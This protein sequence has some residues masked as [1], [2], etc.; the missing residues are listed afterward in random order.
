M[1]L[2]GMSGMSGMNNSLASTMN[3]TANIASGLN[4]S[5]GSI[6][7]GTGS[8]LGSATGSI[9]GKQSM[10]AI[11][12]AVPGT[13]I[14]G[15]VGF[16]NG[17]LSEAMQSANV[18]SLLASYQQRKA[19]EQAMAQNPFAALLGGLGGGGGGATGGIQNIFAVLIQA[20]MSMFAGAGQAQ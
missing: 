1:S 19:Q 8:S 6:L 14:S 17:K 2:F 13:S 20:M 7:G 11:N 12:G 10:N 4:L 5:A 16:V 15:T 18:D 9:I 3:L